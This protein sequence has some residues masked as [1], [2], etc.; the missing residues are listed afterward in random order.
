MNKS[1]IEWCD[2]VFNPIT[3]CLH[4]CEYCY[5]RGIAQRFGGAYDLMQ[6]ENIKN[7]PPEMMKVYED[8][9]PP[10]VNT[11]IPYKQKNG[12]FIK[13]PFPYG[14]YPTFHRYRLDEPQKIK[15]PQTVFVGSMADVFGDWVPDEWIRE[16]F[17]ACGDAPQ[18]RYLFL[19]KNSDRY[20]ALHGIIS[21]LEWNKDNDFEF[22]LGMSVT[23]KGFEKYTTHKLCSMFLSI[24]PLLAPINN[25]NLKGIKWVI[26]GAETGN[27]KGKIIPKREWIVDIVNACR[28][29]GVPIFL[30]DNLADIWQEPL[31][32]QFPWEVNEK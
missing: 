28:D 6:D 7:I 27:R 2:M 26:I 10:V 24:E 30:K 1:K 25:I 16:V 22:W 12:S 13:A 18:H 31:I 4:G 15:K 11:P 3:G 5:A 20:K 32:Q 8:D 21:S 23:G 19:T 29:A 9:L 14:F 17:K